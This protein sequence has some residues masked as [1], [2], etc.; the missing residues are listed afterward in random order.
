MIRANAEFPLETP[1][2]YSASQAYLAQ[3][4]LR[5]RHAITQSA[6]RIKLRLIEATSPAALV[7]QH[8]WAMVG[9]AAIAGFA[10]ARCRAQTAPPDAPAVAA[11]ERTRPWYAPLLDA[12]K[13]AIVEWGRVALASAIT[14]SSAA[15]LV[16]NLPGPSDM[17]AETAS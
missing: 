12:A 10:L 17:D 9:A 14:A 8:P 11:P 16:S 2:A 4:A 7:R 3:R 1:P 15:D 6:A 5:E 13:N